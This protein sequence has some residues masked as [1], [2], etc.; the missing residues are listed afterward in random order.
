MFRKQAFFSKLTQPLE[1]FK[2]RGLPFQFFALLF[3][4]GFG[5][6]FIFSSL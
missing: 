2:Q 4:L 3:G 1:L 6:L 5:S